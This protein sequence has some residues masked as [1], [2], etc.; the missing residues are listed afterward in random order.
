MTGKGFV[1][2]GNDDYYLVD[3]KIF[4]K[5]PKVFEMIELCDDLKEYEAFLWLDLD[6]IVSKYLEK[7]EW[8][9]KNL[10]S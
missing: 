7:K 1:D 4:I 3:W 10:Y 8:L 9:M 6:Y 2:F 5:L